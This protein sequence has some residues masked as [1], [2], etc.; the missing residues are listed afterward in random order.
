MLDEVAKGNASK[1]GET[2]S[3]KR[4]EKR[5]LLKLDKDIIPMSEHIAEVK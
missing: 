1:I 5:Y 4:D 2:Q 3:G